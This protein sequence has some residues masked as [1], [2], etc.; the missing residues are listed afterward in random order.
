M[1]LNFNTNDTITEKSINQKKVLPSYIGDCNFA[2]A[3][4]VKVFV[5]AK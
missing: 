2:V 3:Q 5:A 1:V 4:Y